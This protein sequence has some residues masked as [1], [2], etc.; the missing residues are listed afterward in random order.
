[1]VGSSDDARF[2]LVELELL[3]A[4]RKRLLTVE[5]L[6]VMTALVLPV[7]LCFV[8]YHAWS[9]GYPIRVLFP[10]AGIVFVVMLL[11]T[12]PVALIRWMTNRRFHKHA[13]LLTPGDVHS[14]GVEDG[15]VLGAF[16]I[17]VSED[18]HIHAFRSDV[19]WARVF[20]VARLVL[21]VVIVSGLGVLFWQLLI[22]GPRAL[23]IVKITAAIVGYLAILVAML[24]DRQTLEW[25][26]HPG[27]GKLAVLTL[28]LRGLREVEIDMNRV[29]SAA[30]VKRGLFTKT[31]RLAALL[32]DGRVVELPAQG[33]PVPTDLLA[34]DTEVVLGYA[35]AARIARV[36]GFELNPELESAQ[37]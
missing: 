9:S 25:Q 2:M 17:R 31:V 11:T 10:I 26:F 24:C 8:G 20:W 1:M 29:E 21:L 3:D 19:R 5:K 32:D 35:R 16:R 30:Y 36:L 22:G 33:F 34:D 23:A 28:G 37:G 7:A 4:R 27:S 12:I 6:F 13:A 18:G 14:L 15:D